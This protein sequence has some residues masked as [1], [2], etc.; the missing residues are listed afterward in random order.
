MKRAGDDPLPSQQQDDTQPAAIVPEDKPEQEEW[1]VDEIL[2]AKKTRRGTKLLVKWTGYVRPTWEPL[3]AFLDT[4]ALDRYE[5][6]NGRITGTIG[7]ERRQGGRERR[8]V[9]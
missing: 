1:Q 3:S 4:E 8:G 9:L 2:K 7:G 5:A 6:T